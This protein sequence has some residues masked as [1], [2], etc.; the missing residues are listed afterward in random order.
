MVAS[1]PFSGAIDALSIVQASGGFVAV[2]CGHSRHCVRF[3]RGIG[4]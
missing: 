3:G 2:A 1:L 4:R